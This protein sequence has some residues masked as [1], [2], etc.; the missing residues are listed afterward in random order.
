[1]AY[2]TELLLFVVFIWGVFV[3]K[4][5]LTPMGRLGLERSLLRR[6]KGIAVMKHGNRK[7]EQVFVDFTN[8]EF[9]YQNQSYKLAESKPYYIG[10]IPVVEYNV[11][12]AEPLVPLEFKKITHVG[13]VICKECNNPTEAS[14]EVEEPVMQVTSSSKQSEFAGLLWAYL[15]AKLLGQTQLLISIAAIGALLG[16]LAGVYLAL[17]AVPSV[18]AQCQATTGIVQH[19]IDIMNQS[20]ITHTVKV[21]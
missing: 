1:M 14:I 4:Y 8:P 7:W 20:V 17:A 16:A 5:V 10:N 18:G 21:I 12:N 6:N 3:D 15:Q 9:K 13:T 19:C 2:E 11:G